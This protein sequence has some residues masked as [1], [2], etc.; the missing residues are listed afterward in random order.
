MLSNPVPLF[1]FVKD[2]SLD[3]ISQESAVKDVFDAIDRNRDNVL[4]R[5]DF[6]QYW[7]SL[8]KRITNNFELSRLNFIIRIGAFS[9]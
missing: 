6:N 4:L 3:L 2:Q 9:R 1:Q 5:E 7:A 8:G